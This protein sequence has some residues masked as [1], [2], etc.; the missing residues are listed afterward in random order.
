[1]IFFNI[2]IPDIFHFGENARQGYESRYER[3]IGRDFRNSVLLAPLEVSLSN[4]LDIRNRIQVRIDREVAS[5]TDMTHTLASLTSADDR[6]SGATAAVAIATSTVDGTD[7]HRDRDNRR[8]TICICLT[9][10]PP[11]YHRLRYGF[12]YFECHIERR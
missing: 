6:L 10:Q 12:Y 4:L 3:K 9:H 11:S 5:G 2:P 8:G 1:M 7:P